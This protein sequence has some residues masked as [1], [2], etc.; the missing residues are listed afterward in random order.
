MSVVESRQP[1]LV[2]E[3]KRLLDDERVL[4]D[5][6]NR[7]LYAQDVH[8]KA[9][10]AL[11]VVRPR[12]T[13]ELASL[14][15][16]IT[17]A[18]HA[19]IAR[20]GGMSYT[21]GYVPQEESSVII[22]TQFMDQVLE[23][24]TEDMYVT[25]QCGC[26]W[27]T[28]REALDG[29]GLR[30]PF[31]GTLSGIQA[32]VGGG[33]SQNCIFWGSARHGTAADSV[34]SLDVVLA[35]GSVVSTGAN[36]QQHAT[37]FFRHFGPDLTGLFT[38]DTGAMGIKATATLRLLPAAEHQEYLSFNFAEDG[39]LIAAMSEIARAGL[40]DE[41]FA[42]DPYLASLR[43]ERD[44][45]LSDVKKLAGVMKAGG[46]VTGAIKEG[47]KVAIAGRRFMKD[48]QY[49]LHISLEERVAA[50]AQAAADEVRTIC[51]KH[52]GSE[53]ENS[54]P[55][56]LRAN[57]FTPLNNVV[58]PN[59]E[60]WSP[61]HTIVPHSKAASTVAAVEALFAR[62]HEAIEKHGIGVGFLLATV[63]TNGFVVEPVLYTP[64]ELTE[65]HKETIEP[66]VLKRMACFE[67]NPEAMLTTARLRE[68]FADLC[69][70]TGGIHMQIGKLYR[71]K[72]GL[73]PESWRVVD[74]IKAALDPKRRV[75]PG[76]LG[77]D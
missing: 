59:G 76:S 69:C 35:D 17:E 9:G 77:L 55:K 38:A 49:S 15:A 61:V 60:R 1:D 51:G 56:I 46:S 7:V 25:V 12:D 32:T 29:T 52:G 34:L 37:P 26:S 62:H 2:D 45:M 73:A 65:I 41:C 63:S 74:K 4:T 75:N 6:Y 68:E 5:D 21:S 23:V 57:P 16:A 36:A 67:A 39:P 48:V 71:Y 31:W 66:P 27:K 42:F 14:V 28:L 54:I 58:G 33:L 24:N 50:A 40:A 44:S 13:A 72:E 10:P 3:L 64:H 18:G 11:A 30:T 43:M 19:V 70:E 20:G 47:A 8:T 22:D 53:I